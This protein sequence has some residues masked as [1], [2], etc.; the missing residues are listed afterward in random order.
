MREARLHIP[1]A[2]AGRPFWEVQGQGDAR[3]YREEG[4]SWGGTCCTRPLPPPQGTLAG[5]TVGGGEPVSHPIH[6]RRG[7][8][9]STLPLACLG[10]FSQQLQ[11]VLPLPLFP[12][13]FICCYTQMPPGTPRVESPSHPSLG[14]GWAIA[15]V[16]RGLLLSPPE[17]AFVF[18]LQKQQMLRWEPGAGRET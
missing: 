6:P 18:F 11:A 4:G 12:P 8:V 16:P 10:S 3:S 17:T 14:G 2:L 1:E 9:S 15:F 5:F 13:R 7:S